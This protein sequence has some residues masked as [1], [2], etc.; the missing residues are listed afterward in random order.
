MNSDPC[1]MFITDLDGT[2]LRSDGTFSPTDIKSL[3][4]LGDNGIV[5][6]IAT[7]RSLYSFNRAIEID[8]PVDYLIFSTGVGVMDYQHKSIVRSIHIEPDNRDHAVKTLVDMDLDFMVH[9]PVPDN[10]HFSYHASGKD[11]P[12]F[13]RRI[14]RYRDF[15]RP[16]TESGAI[17]RN[18]SQ[19]LAVVDGD[20][21]NTVLGSLAMALPNF[22]VIRSTSPLDGVSTWIEIFHGQVSKSRAAAWL[23]NCLKIRSESIVA[24]GNDYN[25]MDL[26]EWAGTGVVVENAP[27]D[28]KSRYRVM[29]SNNRCGVSEA[30][31]K[32]MVMR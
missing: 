4:A 31:E 23:A 5:R 25:D 6:V 19:L 15:A 7:G 12:D 29:A 18:P 8:L 10:H 22:A 14:D 32:M 30:I 21:C 24:I 16:L 17:S 1:R 2:L 13:F 11:N 20:S 27:E 3:Q 28:L 9:D 26:L